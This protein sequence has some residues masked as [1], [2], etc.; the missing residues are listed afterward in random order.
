MNEQNSEQM[1][2]QS[3]EW[4][5]SEVP[6]LSQIESIRFYEFWT[7]NN[8]KEFV[9]SDVLYHRTNNPARFLEKRFSIPGRVHTVQ[10]GL[11]AIVF[12][13][14]NRMHHCQ[15]TL[16][17]DSIIAYEISTHISCTSSSHLD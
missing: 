5:T 16:F 1:K 12:S 14:P 4:L 2:K 15:N 9:E 8:R 3:E 13:H 6:R 17:V 11:D 7:E 10:E